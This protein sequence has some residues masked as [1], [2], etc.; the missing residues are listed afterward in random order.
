M[1][2]WDLTVLSVVAVFLLLDVANSECPTWYIA[3]G[4]ECVCG[5]TVHGGLKCDDFNKTVDISAGYCMTYDDR[6]PYN[7]SSLVVGE[8][9]FG[10]A[11]H[12]TNRI[13]TRLPPQ[14]TQVNS[15]QCDPYNRE[16]LF[17]GECRAGFG[18][19]VYSLDLHCANCSRMSTATAVSLYL[20][21]E[22][23]P[24]T[25]LFFIVLI[26]RP[27]LLTGPQL[28]YITFCQAVVNTF[29]YSHHLYTTLFASLPPLLR[30]AVQMS[31][32]MAGISSLKFFRFITPPFCIS[33]RVTGLHVQLLGFVTSFYS[34]FL[35]ILTYSIIEL[36]ARYG[37]V[38]S[39][40]S[41]G[42]NARAS[43]VHAFATFTMLSMFSNMCQ[44][45]TILLT[46]HVIDITGK[47]IK[48]VLFLEPSI[49][50]YSWDHLPY[51]ITTLLVLFIFVACPALFLLIYPTRLYGRLVHP[52]SSRKQL[53]LKIFAETLNCGFKDG[54]RGTRDYRM[55]LALL[56]LASLIYSVAG[57]VLGVNGL[58][59]CG[60]FLTSVSLFLGSF[61]VCWIKPCKTEL[62]NL[63][64]G[65]HYTLLGILSLEFGLWWQDNALDT[66]VLSFG[67]VVVLLIPHLLAVGLGLKKILQKCSSYDFKINFRRILRQRKFGLKR[68]EDF[69]EGQQNG[70][71]QP[72]LQ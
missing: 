47:S 17:C 31:L 33:D 9:P 38:K 20:L 72:L 19:A 53:A 21:L 36:N 35:V 24:I 66:R 54:L 71:E 1:A 42:I 16:G 7:S 28:G 37:L 23:L 63:S 46:S 39:F 4:D 11:A 60:M 32:V 27:S 3:K 2:F 56:I 26:Y 41:R 58:Y 6:G 22:L 68:T 12:V 49:E 59:G 62:T 67:G 69:I 64:L 30:V 48:E 15:S 14:P 52:L 25:T 70:E 55:V 34:L 5:A 57:P 10:R 45:Y 13:Y 40:S 43:V 18:P 8:C 51:L 50:M 44:G 61:L 29:Q 65:F